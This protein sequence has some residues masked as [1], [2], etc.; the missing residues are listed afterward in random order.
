MD[1]RDL[2]LIQY[3]SGISGSPK[4]VMLSHRNLLANALQIRSWLSD[5]QDGSE[6]FL[7]VTPIA[8]VLGSTTV[9]NLPITQGACIVLL[10]KFQ[11]AE[12]LEAIKK[13]APSYFP[14]VPAMY[15]ALN[16]FPNVR[17]YNIQSIRACLSSG[18]PLPVEVEEAFEKLAKA[19]LVE[20]YGLT[21][22][23]PLTHSAP[24]YGHDKVGSI[25]LPLPS[26]EARIV[27]LQTRRPLPPGQVGELAV[28]GPQIMI[29]YWRDDEATAAAIDEL[30]WL[31]TGDIARMD[32]DG[33]FQIISR[34][35]D[36]GFARD[37]DEIYPRDIEEIL[38]ELPAV[39]EPI[40]SI[41]AGRP[42]A[43]IRL[44]KGAQITAATITAYCERRL[45]ADHV[46]W[47]VLFV[48]EFPRN[49][50]GHV[51]RRELVDEYEDRL[52]VSAGG[53]GRYLSGLQESLEPVQR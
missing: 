41:I 23:S 29:G 39:D 21:E 7:A 18:A 3:T 53:P 37:G 10:P 42:V 27:D 25:G 50:L 32:E 34:S 22:A 44:K 52:Q 5:A 8:H 28:R 17:K 51:L 19:R 11:A 48:S 38:Y 4:G 14:G 33:Y 2:A 49:I 31:Y 26:T 45:P 43:F 35:Q 40:V 1:V 9:M 30:G 46:P 20:S 16:N 12:V 6:T 13:H 47:R 15:V 36:M 24:L